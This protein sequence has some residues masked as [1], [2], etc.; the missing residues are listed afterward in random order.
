[1]TSHMR[2]V[3]LAVGLLALIGI[4][5][6]HS[7]ADEGSFQCSATGGADFCKC[8]GAD[9]CK[10]MRKSGVCASA[11]DCTVKND[12]TTCTCTATLKAGTGT[13]QAVPPLKHSPH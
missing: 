3:G 7:H 12:V 2:K 5:F 13:I 4:G 9:N 11:L 6:S 10:T 8:K 1:M